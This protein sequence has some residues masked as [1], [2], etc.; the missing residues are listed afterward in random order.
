[1]IEGNKCNV[2]AVTDYS[3]HNNLMFDAKPYKSK[4]N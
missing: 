2:L 3:A 1:M 4:I